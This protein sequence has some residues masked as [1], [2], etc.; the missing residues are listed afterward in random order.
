MPFNVWIANFSDHPSHLPK[1]QNRGV[2]APAP[3]VIYHREYFVDATTAKIRE[4]A[5]TNVIEIQVSVSKLNN[6][7]RRNG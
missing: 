1:H 5:D 7:I 2:V 3:T 6:F 4:S